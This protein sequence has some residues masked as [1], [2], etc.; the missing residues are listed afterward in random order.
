MR[1]VH[2]SHATA[3]LAS[4]ATLAFLSAPVHANYYTNGTWSTSPDE[5]NREI[6][7]DAVEDYSGTG[8]SNLNQCV[9]GL[10]DFIYWMEFINYTRWQ[11]ST[12]E[13]AWSWDFEDGELD[14]TYGDAGDFA[15]FSGHG[16]TGYAKFN[17]DYGDNLYDTETLLGNNDL[18]FMAF[19]SCQTV[20]AAGRTDFIAA[21]EGL[22]LHF[23]FGFQSTALDISTTARNYGIYNMVGYTVR[24]AWVT[25]T[26][27][28]HSSSKTG[29]YVRFYEAGCDTL[30]ETAT[31]FA[32]DPE[33]VVST[34]EFTW[35][36]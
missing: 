19:D 7:G 14:E 34:V 3:T 17:G 31:S 28:G 25:A 4:L 30:N 13:D 24:N 6:Y 18:E 32:C 9:N 2:R 11:Y 1:H 27:D 10:E 21:N 12:D 35:T 36:L 29:A 8:S 5:G 16:S 26:M 22:G 15:Y 20:N 23:V 33:G